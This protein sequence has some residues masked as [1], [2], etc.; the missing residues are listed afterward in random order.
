MKDFRKT[1]FKFKNEG[2]KKA[3]ISFLVSEGCTI[4]DT[5]SCATKYKYLYVTVDS[6]IVLLSS[7]GQFEEDTDD[8]KELD[9]CSYLS[10]KSRMLS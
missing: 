1:K 5:E 2:D 9:P 3:L 4:S 7:D 6:R 8:Y 10:W